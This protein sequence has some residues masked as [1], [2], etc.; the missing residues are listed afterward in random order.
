MAA[1]QTACLP[2]FHV[3]LV[4]PAAPAGSMTGGRMAVVGMALVPNVIRRVRVR[5][6]P[7]FR[8]R[9]PR[10]VCPGGEVRDDPGLRSDRFSD[11]PRAATGRMR[12]GDLEEPRRQFAVDRRAAAAVRFF[13]QARV[14]HSTD[15]RQNAG[16]SHRAIF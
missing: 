5:L 14:D 4:L 8:G 2:V 11:D 1:V 13:L 12:R 10:A 9:N 7:D 16:A 3:R 6:P 15:S